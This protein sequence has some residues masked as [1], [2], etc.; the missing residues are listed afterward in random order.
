LRGTIP[1]AAI[2]QRHVQPRR[3]TNS[4]IGRVLFARSGTWLAD[5]VAYGMHLLARFWPAILIRSLLNASDDLD[6]SKAKQRRSY[7]L[8]H[9]AQLAFFQRVAESG[10]PLSVRQTGL[11]NDLHQFTHLPVYPLEQITCPT[12]V[13]HGRAD[14]NVPLAH[15]EFVARVV[16]NAELFALVG[17]GFVGHNYFGQG[18]PREF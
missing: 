6:R 15:A 8:R 13:V 11:W 10:M 9:P 16:P 14:G 17:N 4:L 12:L 2:S 3:T 7:V 18:V 5:L 1:K